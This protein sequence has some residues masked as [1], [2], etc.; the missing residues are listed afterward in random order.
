MISDPKTRTHRFKILVVGPAGAG[1]S[2]IVQRL[3]AHLAP[4]RTASRDSGSIRTIGKTSFMGPLGSHVSLSDLSVASLG[5]PEARIE[6]VKAS[7]LGSELVE[8]GA[9]AEDGFAIVVHL[10]WL[11]VE[12]VAG[13]IQIGPMTG[14][15]MRNADQIIYVA[16]ELADEAADGLDDLERWLAKYAPDTRIAAFFGAPMRDAI[17]AF[18]AIAPLAAHVI[19]LA[20]AQLAAPP[21]APK[22]KA[23]VRKKTKA[24]R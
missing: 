18:D 22:K 1:K 13:R 12:L 20:R 16:G 7:S 23:R 10:H 24:R 2:S 6:R 9:V 21:P 3:V 5:A 14:D 17:P 11:P 15:W 19:A 4:A 8:T